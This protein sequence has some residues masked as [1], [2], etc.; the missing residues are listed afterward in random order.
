M[1]TEPAVSDFCWPFDGRLLQISKV[2]FACQDVMRLITRELS[3]SHELDQDGA[4]ELASWRL[5]TP[6]KECFPYGRERDLRLTLVERNIPFSR[7]RARMPIS[8]AIAAS[9]ES[10]AIFHPAAYP[11]DDTRATY[12]FRT[13]RTREP[14]F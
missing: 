2:L 12:F 11:A 5:R 6:K 8:W 13:S 7:A 14:S 1:S 10:C 4:K 9:L 3:W